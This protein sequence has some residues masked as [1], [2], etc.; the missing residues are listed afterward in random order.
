[1]PKVRDG[2]FGT[3]LRITAKD[4]GTVVDISS[5][6]ARTIYLRK[7]NVAKTILTK[8][9]VLST[10]GSDG[11]LEYITVADDVDAEGP[12]GIQG[13]VVLPSGTFRTAIGSF[14]VGP[15]IENL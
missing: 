12:W 4:N 11:K 8:T 13:E 9:A 2:D 6:T 3:K 1:M 10:D 5:S 7:A 14:N 15:K